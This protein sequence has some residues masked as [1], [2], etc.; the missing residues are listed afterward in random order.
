MVHT[1]DTQESWAKLFHAQFLATP[2]NILDFPDLYSPATPVS[3][4]LGFGHR[5]LRLGGMA[6]CMLL[7]EFAQN[8]VINGSRAIAA[9]WGAEYH[10]K[11]GMVTFLLRP[12][13][14]SNA[15]QE[16]TRLPAVC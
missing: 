6:Y 2:S 12:Q 11:G 5:D 16:Q 13:E 3:I 4:G 8:A 14:L 10:P 9:L 7:H 1:K 15:A